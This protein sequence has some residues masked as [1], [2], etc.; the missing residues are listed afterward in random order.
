MRV[1]ILGSTTLAGTVVVLLAFAAGDCSAFGGTCPEAPPPLL[2]DD[3]ARF[4]G[5]GAAWVVAPWV[6]LTEPSWRRLAIAVA[7]AAGTFLVVALL[8]RSVS[9]S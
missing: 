5:L 7:W 3:T 8:A 4:A 9:A 6:Y 1:V 2:D